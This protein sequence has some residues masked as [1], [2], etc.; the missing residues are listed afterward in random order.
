MRIGMRR[1][2]LLPAAAALGAL[3]F[4]STGCMQYAPD[5]SVATP[6]PPGQTDSSRLPPLL[7]PLQ[8]AGAGVE[9][10]DGTQSDVLAAQDAASPT[11]VPGKDAGLPATSTVAG[12]RTPNPVSPTATP[13]RTPTPARTPAPGNEGQ[14]PTPTPSATPT[15]TPTTTST[16]TP[17]PTVTPSP[18]PVLPQTEGGLTPIATPPPEG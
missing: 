1:E 10:F 8:G 14:T 5:G 4:V 9:V 11:T 13:T 17:T 3:A 16:A 15:P 12:E 6:P 2:R 18:T 7:S